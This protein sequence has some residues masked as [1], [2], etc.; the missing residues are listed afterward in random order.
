MIFFIRKIPKK[1]EIYD[2]KIFV[3]EMEFSHV[4]GTEL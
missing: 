3:E 1:G 2:A 4:S